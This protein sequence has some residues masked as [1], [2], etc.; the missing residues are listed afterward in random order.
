MSKHQLI[1]TSCRKGMY[2]IYDG[3][4]VFSHDKNITNESQY[5]HLKKYF[6]YPKLIL[7]SDAIKTM[8]PELGDSFVEHLYPEDETDETGQRLNMLLWE[9]WRQN[10]TETIF[11]MNED[12]IPRM[13]KSFIYEK[14]ENGQYAFVRLSYLG[15]DY[16]GPHG[17]LGNFLSHIVWLENEKSE[18]YPCEYYKSNTLKENID[19]ALV[20]S[21]EKPDFLPDPELE[22]GNLINFEEIS[23]FLRNSTK[24]ELF[25]NMLHAFIASRKDGKKIII[26]DSEENVLKW[27]AA[28][29]YVFPINY[30]LDININSYVFDPEHTTADICG[31]FPYGTNYKYDKFAESAYV[32]DFVRN[33]FPTFDN[34]HRFFNFIKMCFTMS[35]ENLKA[36]HNFLLNGYSLNEVDDRIFDAYTLYEFFAKGIKNTDEKLMEQALSFSNK[37]AATPEKE[38]LIRLILDD[39]E[40]K[41]CNNNLFVI[42]IKHLASSMVSLDSSMKDILSQN[43]IQRFLNCVE[44]NEISY[45][46]FDNFYKDTSSFAS[47]MDLLVYSQLF[48]DI[49]FNSFMTVVSRCTNYDKLEKLCV[50]T[51]KVVSNEKISLTDNFIDTKY[52]NLYYTIIT[53]AF[54][55]GESKGYEMTLCALGTYDDVGS[56]INM[57]LNL[58][59]IVLDNTSDSI[60]CN[61][62]WSNI[63]NKL[64]NRSSDELNVANHILL[65][66]GRTDEVYDLYETCFKKLKKPSDLKAMFYQHYSNVVCKQKE[67]AQKYVGRVFDLYYRSLCSFHSDESD[68]YLKDLLQMII[69]NNYRLS[70]TND[71]ISKVIDQIEYKAGNDKMLIVDIY[72]FQRKMNPESIDGKVHLLMLAYEMDSDVSDFSWKERIERL[73]SIIPGKKAPLNMCGTKEQESYLN[74][75]N[76]NVF[77]MCRRGCNIE[78]IF[79]MYEMTGYQKQCLILYCF[80]NFVKQAKKDDDK[81]PYLSKY[82]MLIIKKYLNDGIKKE[83]CGALLGLNKNKL[84]MV[85]QFITENCSDPS[86]KCT[87]SD[88]KEEIDSK[89]PVSKFVQNIFRKFKK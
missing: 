27:T 13:P 45:G 53:A 32:F 22:V 24:I 47:K 9:R 38:R 70:F 2:S 73:N 87:W 17:R 46:A 41:N 3:Q 62:I 79:N 40:L 28:I 7:Y 68:Q 44:S 18:H 36:F 64:S 85:D 20:G 78:R 51:G 84:E 57:T 69:R 89:N 4:N 54:R 81:I 83:I 37:Y 56:I 61:R 77:A 55:L 1:Y 50:M 82:M 49:Y 23:Q 72:N 11:P 15:H 52:G 5:E 63:Y 30:I 74:W 19:N 58:E 43:I 21:S 66:N 42:L 80:E 88:I 14:Q 6:G 67:Y 25:K 33:S 10:P 48:S 60:T 31:V 65:I 26:C 75:I 59:G 8:F 34:S 12:I 29:E 39:D 35:R 16:M 76:P 86:D 71:L